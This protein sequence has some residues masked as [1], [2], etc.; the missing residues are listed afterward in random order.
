[1]YRFTDFNLQVPSQVQIVQLF[2][3][4]KPQNAQFRSLKIL[5]FNLASNVTFSK[6]AT[7]RSVTVY[8]GNNVKLCAKHEFIMS[9]NIPGE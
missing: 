6:G 5:Y 3:I 8:Y 4:Y 1:M 9:I 2:E 7:L